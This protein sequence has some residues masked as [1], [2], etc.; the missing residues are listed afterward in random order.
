[1]YVYIF[2]FLF[3]KIQCDERHDGG[4]KSVI[5]LLILIHVNNLLY[6]FEC[7]WREADEKEHKDEANFQRHQGIHSFVA[8]RLVQELNYNRK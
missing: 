4:V 7:A 3:A 8:S 5:R 1:M 2:N 6:T